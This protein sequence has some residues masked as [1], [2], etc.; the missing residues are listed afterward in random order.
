MAERNQSSA[1]EEVVS[2]VENGPILRPSAPITGDVHVVHDFDEALEYAYERFHTDADDALNWTDLREREVGKIEQAGGAQAV[3]AMWERFLALIPPRLP[4]SYEEIQDDI[5]ADLFHVAASRAVFGDGDRL[6]DRMW[7][8][9][10]QGGWPCG[11]E[12]EYPEGRLVVFQ[13][14]L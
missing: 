3:V 8:A 1:V 9:Y 14:S 5:V 10:K 11:W 12:G 2:F 4:E 13:P 7:D 6:F